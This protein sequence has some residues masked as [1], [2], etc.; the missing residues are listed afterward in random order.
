MAARAIGSGTISFGLV[1]I[2]FKLYTAASPAN[3]SFNMLHKKC[4]S[5]LKQQLLCPVDNVVVERSDTVKG[6][7]FAKD[8]YVQ[9]SEEELKKL[10][11]AKT[12]SLELVEFVPESTVDLVYLEKSYYL[13]PDKGGEK[14]YR[15][16]TQAMERADKIAVGRFWTRGKEQLVLLRPYRGKGLIMHQVFYANEVRSFDEV[17]PATAEGGGFKDVEIELAQKLIEQL[18]VEA[19]EPSRFRDEYEDRV[20]AAVEQKIA[21]REIV[22]SEEAPKAQIIDLFEALKRSLAAGPAKAKPQ[23]ELAPPS[24]KPP[25]K[26]EPRVAESKKRKSAG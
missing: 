21:G 25:K 8:Q 17:A 22:V 16:L 10:E 3:V 11:A 13:G 18:S 15:L 6:F 19:F 5:R 20:R 4:G 9:F 24:V 7:E 12:D 26:A 23:E 1:S 2:P 14:A